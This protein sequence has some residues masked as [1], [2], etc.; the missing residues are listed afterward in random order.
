M[1]W[2][3]LVWFGLVWHGLGL[4][5]FNFGKFL[6]GCSFG[7]HG[8]VLVGVDSVDMVWFWLEWFGLGW[9]GVAWH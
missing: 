6:A 1:V 7:W 2:I 8:V 5:C 3:R 4:V 9:F